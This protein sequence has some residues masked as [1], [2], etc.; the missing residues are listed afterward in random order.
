M[1]QPVWQQALVEGAAALGVETPARALGPYQRHYELVLLHNA[2]A[3]LTT[4]T[5]PAEVAIKHFLDSLTCLLARDIA[6][7]ER[8]A[9]VG[10]GAGFPGLVLAVA[11]P[12]AS[13]TLI[14]SS[15]KRARF[16]EQT[17]EALGLAN[18]SVVPARAETAGRQ[19]EHR[20][21]HQLA[22]SRAVAA[23]PVLLEYCLPLVRVGGQ[24]LAYKGPEAEQEL[25][26]SGE[27]LARLGGRVA[28]TRRLRLPRD[29]GERVLVLV[30]KVAPTP[31]GYPRRPGVPARRPLGGC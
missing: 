24:V 17:A 25:K 31:C 10:S 3:G 5:E 13:F 30:E 6:P 23:L 9:D 22:V 29:M 15:Q 7:G 16:L 14:E 12:A 11:R 18:V 1:G 4:L 27:A 19:A 20:E 28:E 2:R 26:D 8:V 21:R